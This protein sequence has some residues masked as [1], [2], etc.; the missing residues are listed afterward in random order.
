MSKATEQSIKHKLKDISKALK[1]PF[2]PLLETLV[3]MS[4]VEKLD[5]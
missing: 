3:A 4:S 1:I 5:R 2:N